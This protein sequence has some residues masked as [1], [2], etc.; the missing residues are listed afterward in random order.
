[1]ALKDLYS[2]Y[3]YDQNYNCAETMIR[4]GNEYYGLELHDRDMIA[5]GGFGAGIQTGNTCGAI[6][7]AVSILSMRY[8]EKKAH[9]STDIRPVTTALIRKFNERYGSVL[10]KDIK[11]QSF[12][13]DIRCKHT[14]EAACDILEQVIEEYDSRERSMP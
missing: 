3:Y 9:E 12:Q 2:K 11:P 14:I 13:P 6:L 10:C 7:S 5:F 8:V 4:A 1:M